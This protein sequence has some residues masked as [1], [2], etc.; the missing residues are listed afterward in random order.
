[1]TIVTA[2]TVA[3]ITVL[4]AVTVVIVVT[5]VTVVISIIYIFLQSVSIFIFIH[6]HTLTFNFKSYLQFCFYHRRFRVCAPSALSKIRMHQFTHHYWHLSKAIILCK[7]DDL[8]KFFFFFVI[9]TPKYIAV[10]VCET[11]NTQ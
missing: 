11:N 1:M 3:V 8:N 6:S 9:F 5:V 10:V 2:V 4:I 7:S